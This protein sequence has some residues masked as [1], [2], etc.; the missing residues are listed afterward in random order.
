MNEQI[1]RVLVVSVL[2]LAFV[3]STA[4]TMRADIREDCRRRLESDRARIDRDAAKYGEHSRRVDHDVDRMD[5]D[6]K[7]CRDHHADWDHSK[8]DIGIYFRH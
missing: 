4:Q 8:F 3:L 5:S 2:V 1:K 7:W 6:R